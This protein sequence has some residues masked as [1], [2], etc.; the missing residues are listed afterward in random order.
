M[1]KRTCRLVIGFTLCLMVLL[2]MSCISVLGDEAGT[3]AAINAAATSAELIT[4]IQSHT[5]DLTTAGIDLTVYNKLSQAS[6]NIVANSL[7]NGPDYDSL[8]SG[9]NP[10]TTALNNAI[11]SATIVRF[12]P[13]I[14][15]MNYISWS[16]GTNV[17]NENNWVEKILYKLDVARPMY[18]SEYLLQNNV[19]VR[20]T[21]RGENN[22]IT[23]GLINGNVVITDI[24]TYWDQYVDIE[25]TID[26]KGI[27]SAVPEFSYT[28]PVT[29]LGANT[30]KAFDLTD[31]IGTMAKSGKS[32]A[33]IF[34]NGLP[35]GFFVTSESDGHKLG[36]YTI[37]DKQGILDAFN[38]ATIDNIGTLIQEN[39]EVFMLNVHEYMNLCT[40]SK[41]EVNKAILAAKPF[42][43]L[44]AIV[45]AYNNFRGSL[46]VTQQYP[47]S[48]DYKVFFSPQPTSKYDFT[49]NN[50]WLGDRTN[51]TWEFDFD[52]GVIDDQ[53]ATSKIM[54]LRSRG[55]SSNDPPYP[56]YALRVR[57]MLSK[58]DNY[59]GV[60]HNIVNLS[61]FSGEGGI[62][63]TFDV[64]KAKISVDGTMK[65]AMNSVVT[66]ICNTKLVLPYLSPKADGETNQPYIKV[67][68]D[69]LAVANGIAASADVTS[70]EAMLDTYH[71][72]LGIAT[73]AQGDY[74][75][76]AALMLGENIE[77][78]QHLQ[79]LLSSS[80]DGIKIGGLLVD[81][82]DYEN[83]IGT[84][85]VKNFTQSDK[86]VKII[87][88]AYNS[89][90][91][92]IAAGIVDTAVDNGMV[93]AQSI[94]SYDYALE[95]VTDVS[96]VRAYLW[97][98]FSD[99]V[100]YCMPK[101]VSVE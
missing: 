80:G 48:E 73:N 68:F 70:A 71:S 53:F 81:Y 12:N 5:E 78:L 66:D 88:A 64:S 10:F 97:D 15:D 91:S 55:N 96:D 62:F 29:G 47:I 69:K 67:S 23:T 43:D 77:S 28:F 84:V 101:I 16:V 37:F 1:V 38:A 99:M 79:T 8:A 85:T 83:V 60:A 72:M 17:N 98:D 14:E 20:K 54:Y 25:T 21:G 4:V 74:S 58:P 63:N 3:L 46:L 57:D 50:L 59:T 27:L 56:P 61:E 65:L 49:D 34:L 89:E 45:T 41:S 87:I 30:L 100:P 86:P 94:K 9:T 93:T 32:T 40:A 31:Y 19:V 92:M 13:I 75:Q 35:A 44:S 36:V 76:Y 39:G 33:A 95:G 90:N 18:K 82:S 22:N 26:Q 42:S 51:E 24:S 7:V 6:K 2:Q 52:L 11:N